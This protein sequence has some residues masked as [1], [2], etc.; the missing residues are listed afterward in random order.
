MMILDVDEGHIPLLIAHCNV[1]LAPITKPVTPLLGSLV[2]VTVA[3]P[4]TTL[5]CPVPVVALFA[6]SVV[7]VVLQSVWSE[8]AVDGVGF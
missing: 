5:H 6:D 8:P 3:V 4:F 7:V 2:V 1:A